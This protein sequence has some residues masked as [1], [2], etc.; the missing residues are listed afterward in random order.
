MDRKGK[1]RIHK[2]PTLF[3]D[4]FSFIIV[5][6]HPQELYLLSNYWIQTRVS[7]SGIYRSIFAR[8]CSLCL[9]IAILPRGIRTYNRTLPSFFTFCSHFFS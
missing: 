4:K 6:L 2:N 7:R 3:L 8:F 9:Y 5:C 1:G